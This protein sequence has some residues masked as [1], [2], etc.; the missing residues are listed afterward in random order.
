MYFSHP[1][2]RS[3]SRAWYADLLAAARAG[4]AG[5]AEHTT[6]RAMQQSIDLWHALNGG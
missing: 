6:H 4:D 5:A 2:A 3:A 1:Q